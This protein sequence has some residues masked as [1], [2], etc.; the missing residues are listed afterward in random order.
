MKLMLIKFTKHWRNA[1]YSI[2]G[3]DIRDFVIRFNIKDFEVIQQRAVD[4][5]P[6]SWYDRSYSVEQY[7]TTYE[8][9]MIKL[10]LP[11]QNL[12]HIIGLVQ[13]YEDLQAD[14]ESREL[15]NQAKFIYRLKHGAKI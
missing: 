8:L 15:I 3:R 4:A 9:N 6:L 11:E 14:A 12:K 2:D 7:F 10:E 13:E 1:V 5:Q